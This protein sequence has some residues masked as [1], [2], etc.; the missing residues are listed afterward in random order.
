MRSR[1][2]TGRTRRTR[3][4]LPGVSVVIPVKDDARYL[5]RCLAALA[6]QT[7]KPREIIVVDNGSR[8]GSRR[9]A[10]RFGARLLRERCRGI[11]ATASRGY[12]AARFPV[13]ARLDADSLP[14][15][16]WI[17]RIENAFAAD[18][19][20][21]ALTGPGDF[22]ALTGMRRRLVDI[23]YMGAYFVLIGAILRQPPVFGSNL[24]MRRSAWRHVRDR[25]HRTD[26]RVHDDLDLSIHLAG[27]PVTLDRDLRVAVSSRPFR[28]LRSLLRRV[29]MG[30]WTVGRN[31]PTLL[32]PHPR[33]PR[34]RSR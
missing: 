17:A 25:V 12:D 24:A 26:R 16:D 8:D 10:R 31:L 27:R 29:A 33:Q 23:G 1:A 13:I 19:R 4:R 21:A 6:A 20:L 11:P 18:T 28:S 3:G 22:P 32:R 30:A 7:S 14:P 5:R 15:A 9:V 34:R 2:V